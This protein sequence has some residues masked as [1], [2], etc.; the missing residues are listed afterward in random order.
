MRSMTMMAGEIVFPHT[1]TVPF[2]EIDTVSLIDLVR[3]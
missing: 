3:A 1:M 2:D